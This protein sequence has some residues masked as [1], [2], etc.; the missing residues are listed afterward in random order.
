MKYQRIITALMAAAAVSC[1]SAQELWTSAD[2]DFS[3]A[4]RLKANVGVECR[5]TDQ[6]SDL[7]RWSVSA[8]LSYR[9]CKYLK[10]G[11]AY[12]FIYDHNGNEY[13]EDDVYTPFYWQPRQR[14]SAGLTGSYKVGRV[15]FSLREM[16]Q[17]TYHRER[18]TS[19]SFD[20]LAN[21]WVFD[22]TLNVKHK[23][24]LRSKL[25]AEYNIRKCRFTPF[26]SCEVYSDVSDFDTSKVRYTI[27][28]E[29]KINSH[30]GLQLFYRYIDGKNTNSHVIGVGYTF[31]L[32]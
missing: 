19:A 27:G 15:T 11:V 6:L 18:V 22:K 2:L 31:K 14:F 23:G 17:Y 5:T 20:V 26:A 25:E 30:N 10:A 4:K 21:E 13:D 24:Y 32:K 8:G 28:S 29:Y 12:K 3:L 16:Y 9:L 7:S 1:A